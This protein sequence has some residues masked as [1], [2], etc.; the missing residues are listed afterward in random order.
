[1]SAYHATKKNIC[2]IYKC[3][4]RHISNNLDPHYFSKM[5]DLRWSKR[6]NFDDINHLKSIN[7][8]WPKRIWVPNIKTYF[9]HIKDKYSNQI[10]SSKHLSKY[11]VSMERYGS[12]LEIFSN[13]V[14]KEEMISRIVFHIK[15]FRDMQNK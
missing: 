13:N 1:M 11:F 3:N 8:K 7:T 4:Y 9:F 10:C 15:W 12:N 14:C 2:T 5:Q 6:F